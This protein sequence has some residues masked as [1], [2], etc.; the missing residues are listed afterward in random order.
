MDDESRRGPG[1]EPAYGGDR[2]P[3]DEQLRDAMAA[4]LGL[5]PAAAERGTDA[6]ALTVPPP[7][8]L[9]S[10]SDASEPA[11]AASATDF[12]SPSEPPLPGDPGELPSDWF[13]VDPPSLA[14]DWPLRDAVGATE[15]PAADDGGPVGAATTSAWLTDDAAAPDRPSP[16]DEAFTDPSAAEFW[17]SPEP[18]PSPEPSLAGDADAGASS[19]NGAADEVPARTGESAVAPGPSVATAVGPD[20]AGDRKEPKA[21]GGTSLAALQEAGLAGPL[22]TAMG[23]L[24]RLYPDGE[25]GERL[26][27]A[28]A[29]APVDFGRSV[30]P[31]PSAHR[32]ARAES[33]WRRLG[34]GVVVA[35]LVVIAFAVVL[36]ARNPDGGRS[37]LDSGARQSTS[38]PPAAS[39]TTV[40]ANGDVLELPPIPEEALL[41]EP[42]GDPAAGT[43]GGSPA[44]SNADRR[45][46]V[47]PRPRA[48]ATSGPR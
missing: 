20:L 5:G 13:R 31:E 4:L 6:P 29:P 44:A 19:P 43:S 32:P 33:R 34:P 23:D 28:P 22:N 7:R 30:E 27:P 41:D 15:S 2:R 45:S 17:A 47:A 38:V 37:P 39:Q 26:A 10:A 18:A 3:D 48:G 14:P 21:D 12:W 25:G 1:P 40:P 24:R 42:G 9:E 11:P 8:R 46:P 35:S 36:L 16:D